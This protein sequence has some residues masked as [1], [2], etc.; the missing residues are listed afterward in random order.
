[1]T[2][3]TCEFV[4]RDYR[5]SAFRL[6]VSAGSMQWSRNLWDIDLENLVDLADARLR[7]EDVPNIPDWHNDKY[8]EQEHPELY[9]RRAPGFSIEAVAENQWI[10]TIHDESSMSVQMDTEDLFSTVERLRA[11]LDEPWERAFGPQPNVWE[12]PTAYSR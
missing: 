9:E 7:G 10:V 3:I 5:G 1:M 6:Q 12:T 2:D 4:E 8:P 11:K